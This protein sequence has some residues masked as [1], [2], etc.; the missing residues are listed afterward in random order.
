MSAVAAADLKLLIKTASNQH[1]SLDKSV[2][3]P[4]HV[5]EFDCW[6][7]KQNMEMHIG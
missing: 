5:L 6:N 1:V 7:H 3:A 4:L 2:Y